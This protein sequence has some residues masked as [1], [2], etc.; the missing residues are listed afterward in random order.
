MRLAASLLCIALLTGCIGGKDG[1]TEEAVDQADTDGTTPTPSPNAPTRPASPTPASTKP[2]AAP[3]TSGSANATPPADAAPT[4]ATLPYEWSSSIANEICVGATLIGCVG[5]VA[6][7]GRDDIPP[8]A[9]TPKSAKLE[10]AW[11]A[12][13]GGIGTMD[14]ALVRAVACEGDGCWDGEAIV[15]VTGASPLTLESDIELAEGEFIV[16][17]A[18]PA[19]MLPEP[20][21]GYAHLESAFSVTGQFV[22]AS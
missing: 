4:L 22:V 14:F 7:E 5:L 3:T 10:L 8:F 15:S 18:R 11:E 17:Y 6:T 2:T 20:L 12:A 21:F 9:G 1:E 13:P 19:S 16:V